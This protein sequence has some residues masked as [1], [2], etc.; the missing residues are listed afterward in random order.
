MIPDEL[1]PRDGR[2]GSGPSKVRADQVE[3]LAALNPGV[4]GTSHRQAPVLGLVQ[5]VQESIAELFELPEG[6]EV[7]LGLG[8]SSTFWDVAVCSLIE[9]RSQHAVFGEFGGKFA[10]AAAR[11]PFLRDP[12]VREAAPGASAALQAE[13]GVDVFATPQNETS[14]GVAVP[15]ERIPGGLTIIDATSAAGGMPID[16]TQVDAYYFAPQKS[17]ASDGGLWIALLSPAAIERAGRLASGDRWIPDSLNLQLAIDNSRK[18]QTINT[19]AIATLGLLEAQLEW[20][21][22]SGGLAGCAA[23]SADSSSRLY[24]WAERSAYARPFVSEPADRSPVVG[25]I[26]FDDTVDAAWLAKS[27]RANG[28]VDTEPYRKLGR[29]QLRIGMYPAVDPEDVTALTRCIDHL[30]S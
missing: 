28:I 17:F 16:L 11:A 18:H 19:P 3:H 21:H 27:L 7:V 14:T 8:G 15:I 24:G 26:D 2:F 1:K 10:A 20:M 9:R 6:Y 13:D 12:S 22:A 30:L 5:R 23:R 4:L 29:N 25:T